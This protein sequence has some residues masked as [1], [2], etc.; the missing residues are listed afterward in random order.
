MVGWE[1]HFGHPVLVI[2]E[3]C[4]SWTQSYELMLPDHWGWSVDRNVF[5]ICFFAHRIHVWYIYLH[6]VSLLLYNMVNVGKYTIHGWYGFVVATCYFFEMIK[7]ARCLFSETGVK[8]GRDVIPWYETFLMRPTLNGGLI[9]N[10]SQRFFN[11]LG[12]PWWYRCCPASL[13]AGI[14]LVDVNVGK[15]LMIC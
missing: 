7:L 12:I 10:S 13:N 1:G 6:L 14:S 15:C 9:S 3:G 4:W 11:C 8:F 2:S 5:Q